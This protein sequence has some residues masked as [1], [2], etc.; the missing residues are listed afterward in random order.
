MHKHKQ[1]HLKNDTVYQDTSISDEID[2]KPTKKCWLL[3]SVNISLYFHVDFFPCLKQSELL[4][5]ALSLIKSKLTIQRDAPSM[6]SVR[7]EYKNKTLQNH[8]L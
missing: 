2:L 1:G 5:S 4:G 6:N 7:S 3:P 8:F